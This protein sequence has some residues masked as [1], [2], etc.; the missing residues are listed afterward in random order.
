MGERGEGSG[1]KGGWGKG[2]GSGECLPLCP[3]PHWKSKM[4]TM[5]VE[6]LFELIILNRKTN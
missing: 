2:E 3:L 5:A 6:T 4:A 1:G